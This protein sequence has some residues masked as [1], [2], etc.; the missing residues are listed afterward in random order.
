MSGHYLLWTWG[1][2]DGGNQGSGLVRV[3]LQIQV[4]Q[5]SSPVSTRNHVV[6][7]QI[8]SSPGANFE[9]GFSYDSA[10]DGG[11]ATTAFLQGGHE[12]V[13]WVRA[14]CEA[15]ITNR[16]AAWV[17]MQSSPTFYFKADRVNWG[18]KICI[19][20]SASNTISLSPFAR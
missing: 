13:V 17:D 15:E 5:F 12:A 16:G 8:T 6:L 18:W 4:D 19:P 1:D 10:V 3:T 9:S 11:A 7:E 2:C 14:I 20:L